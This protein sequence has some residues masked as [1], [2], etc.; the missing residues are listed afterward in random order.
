MFN[1][2][3]VFMQYSECQ[4]LFLP[5]KIVSYQEILKHT[6]NMKY[7]MKFL[8]N[9]NRCIKGLAQVDNVSCPSFVQHHKFFISFTESTKMEGIFQH[10]IKFYTY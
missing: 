8:L 10:G 4:L 5:E 6:V 9:F 1:S 2:N 7:Q 3:M